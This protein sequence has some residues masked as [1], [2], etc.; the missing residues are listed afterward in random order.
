M[1]TSDG[2]AKLFGCAHLR[3][4]LIIEYYGHGRRQGQSEFGEMNYNKKMEFW[5]LIIKGMHD[6]IERVTS[7]RNRKKTNY[8]TDLLFNK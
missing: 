8:K 7:H 5:F 3:D 2:F 1:K 4:R 6:V